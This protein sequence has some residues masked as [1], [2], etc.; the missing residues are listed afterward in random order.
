[1]ND[2]SFGKTDFL[3]E[4]WHKTAAM[5]KGVIYTVGHS[6]HPAEYFL[7]LLQA[8]GVDCVVDVRSVPSSQYN[9]QYNKP[10]LSSYLRNNDVLYLHFGREFGARHANPGLH[11]EEGK[12]D[13]EKVRQTEAFRLG[14]ARLEQG[15]DKGFV[16]ALM[17]AEADPLE[18]H[19]FS[20]ISNYLEAHGIEVRH[21]L[22]NK[23]LVP[24]K[25]LEQE[26]LK[27]FAK[28]LPQPNIFEPD[29]TK[30]D[31]TQAAYRLHNKQV[32]WKEE[33]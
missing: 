32:G 10:N 16:P 13:F 24:H 15:M 19:R 33:K 6:N 12:V 14:I 8:H 30:E 20:M 28:K 31:Q 9:P 29:I 27:K 11:D 7:E 4:I 1:M 17:C 25:K 22:K 23:E 26:I 21:I 3:L 5:P 18:C 2:L